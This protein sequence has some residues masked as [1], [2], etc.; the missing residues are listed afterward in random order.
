MTRSVLRA[1]GLVLLL[2][3]QLTAFGQERAS[4]LACRIF[5]I[6]PASRSLE[7]ACTAS[8]L[9]GPKVEI[10]FLDSFAGIERMSDRIFKPRVR[11]SAGAPL[12]L[13]I[14]GGGLYSFNLP[15][16]GGAISLS[17]EIHF[18]NALEPAQ[19]ALAS[20]LGSEGGHLMVTDL[21]PR[22]C[23]PGGST[24][25]CGNTLRLRVEAPSGWKLATLA[26]MVG[27]NSDW[28]E[29][30]DRESAVIFL[31]QFRERVIKVTDKSGGSIRLAI[32]GLWPFTDQQV[33][34]LVGAI[35]RDQAQQMQGTEAGDFLVTL[36]PFPIPMTGRRS[37]GLARG[38]SIIL[39][40]NPGSDPKLALKHYERHLA[41][42]MFHFYLPNAFRVREDF[43]WFWEG[44]TRYFALTTLLR[45]HQ[46]EAKDYLEA[47]EEEYA[48]YSANGKRGELSLIV[49]APDRFGNPESYEIV[50]RKGMLVAAL[51][52]L[53]LR[54]QS[55]GKHS[56]SDVMR[57]LY[58]NYG[59]RQREVGNKEVIAELLRQ[60]NFK[61]FVRD[62]I[63]GTREIELASTVAAY[64]F[65]V[66]PG[67]T[68]R[69]RPQLVVAPKLSDHQ[70]ELID[71]LSR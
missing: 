64:G 25:A 22:L 30:T 39:L 12:Q 24:A 31:G 20:N 69:S 51:Y 71:G 1:L 54:W 70:R 34:E 33:E 29:I 21:I 65:V 10:R 59:R 37:S 48:A 57:A 60:G 32:A 26:T 13:E 67:T 17:Y 19:Y 49:A 47:L 56:L 36:A 41:H 46:L 52:D 18:S 14:R 27:R 55:K 28:F 15:A 66:D 58:Q 43:D 68:P 45:T 2:S 8:G 44:F 35:A 38:H 11:D 61:L 63:E 4:S 7:V 23:P 3:F 53:E 6:S 62:Y 50:Y 9:S 5:N 16:S 42:E 40:F